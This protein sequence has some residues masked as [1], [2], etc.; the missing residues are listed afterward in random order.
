MNEIKEYTGKI[1]EDIKH[2]DKEGNEYWYARELMPVLEYSKWE[3]FSNTIDNAKFACEKSGYDINDHFPGVGKMVTIGS[4]TKRKIQDY[5]LSR[6]ACYL[7]VQNA[8]PRKKVIALAQTYFAI[9]TRKQELS[10]KE[11][12]LLTE[13]EKRLYR[14]NQ[15]RKGNFSLNKTAVNSGVKDLARFH[16]AGYK[17]L[18]NGETADDIFKRKKLRYREDI[19]DNMGSEELADNIFR[20]AQTAAK[21][22]RDNVDNE[23]TANSVHYEVGKEIRN[24]IEKLGGTMPEKLPTPE[25]SLK[26]IEKEFNSKQKQK[27]TTKE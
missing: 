13:D 15:A 10:E 3:R 4:K 7:I 6:Y 12:R 17:G 2:T 5:K 18:Y 24:T 21:L 26:Q 11:Y 16:N 23:Y 19:L 27:I 9:Q 20:I 14:R 22:K 25:K 8:D 1:F